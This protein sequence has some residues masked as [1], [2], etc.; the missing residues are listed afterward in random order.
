MA[1][2]AQRC[3]SHVGLQQTDVETGTPLTWVPLSLLWSCVPED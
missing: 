1:S 3:S 2:A